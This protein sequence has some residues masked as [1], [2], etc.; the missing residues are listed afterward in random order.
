ML[1][2]SLLPRPTVAVEIQQN[3]TVLPA[4]FTFD[5]KLNENEPHDRLM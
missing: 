4:F 2:C 1:E 3:K 5:W